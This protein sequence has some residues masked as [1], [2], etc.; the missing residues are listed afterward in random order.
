MELPPAKGLN[1]VTQI[2]MYK[3]SALNPIQLKWNFTYTLHAL[4]Q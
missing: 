2:D 3:K 4:L 1:P